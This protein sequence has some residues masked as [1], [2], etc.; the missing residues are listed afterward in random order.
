MLWELSDRERTEDLFKALALADK[1][2]ATIKIVDDQPEERDRQLKIVR[3]A[4]G[5]ANE[6]LAREGNEDR[7][8]RAELSLKELI[9]SRDDLIAH[10]AYQSLLELLYERGAIEQADSLYQSAALLWPDDAVFKSIDMFQNFGRSNNAGAMRVLRAARIERYPKQKSDLMYL[11]ALGGMV[12]GAPDWQTFYADY[13][14]SNH[15][16]RDYVLMMRYAYSGGPSSASAQAEMNERWAK[17]RPST[18]PDRLR[19]GDVSAWREMLLGRFMGAVSVS[20]ILGALT[21]DATWK[22]SDFAHLPMSREGLLTEAWFYEAMRAKAE[23][24]QG[25][26]QESLQRCLD[27]RFTPYL[28]YDMAVFIRSRQ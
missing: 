11:A 10:R 2:E 19:N 1:T 25:R 3:L 28:E 18:W 26:M 17:V 14:S 24:D 7:W 9:E 27:V 15:P 16:Y 21:S 8:D 20:E 5:R 12:T 22:E 23:G 13:L 6:R 4:R